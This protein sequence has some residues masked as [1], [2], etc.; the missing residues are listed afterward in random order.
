MLETLRSKGKKAQTVTLTTISRTVT[1]EGQIEYVEHKSEIDPSEIPEKAVHVTGRKGEYALIDMDP[2]YP[3]YIV[4]DDMIEDAAE[5]PRNWIDANGYFF[6][7][8]D[9]RMSNGF[10]A[11]GHIKGDKPQL[12]FKQILIIGVVVVVALW[13]ISKMM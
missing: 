5:G 12:E 9:Q 8:M 2:I 11:L 7:F 13:M 1:N 10:K 3:D 6:Y 4:D